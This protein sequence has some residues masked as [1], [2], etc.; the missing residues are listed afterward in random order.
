VE[1]APICAPIAA[2][3]FMTRAIKMSTFPLIAWLNV[4]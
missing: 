2:P 1:I 4:P 3:V